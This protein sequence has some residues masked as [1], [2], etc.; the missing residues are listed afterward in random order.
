MYDVM[1]DWEL[2]TYTLIMNSSKNFL[3]DFLSLKM[4]SQVS[5]HYL[6]GIALRVSSPVHHTHLNRRHHSSF[7][8]FVGCSNMNSFICFTFTYVQPFEHNDVAGIAID[9]SA[10]ANHSFFTTLSDEPSGA[11]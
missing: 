10:H 9:P 2:R 4:L 1:N 3:V 7:H 5:W 6:L 8:A 11:V